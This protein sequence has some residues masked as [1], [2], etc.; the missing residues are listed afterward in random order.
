MD[1]KACK[2]PCRLS[3]FRDCRSHNPAKSL[4]HVRSNYPHR[5]PKHWI[6]RNA[7]FWEYHSQTFLYCTDSRNASQTKAPDYTSTTFFRCNDTWY[8]VWYS[9]QSWVAVY[10]GLG[11]IQWPE[12]RQRDNRLLPQHSQEARL[13]NSKGGI[14]IYPGVAIR[15][16]STG[17]KKEDGSRESLWNWLSAGYRIKCT[18]YNLATIRYGI[19]Y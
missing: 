17:C 4:A 12:A 9:T 15:S 16:Q 1:L 7:T 18:I 2:R 3:S 19:W 6:A 11:R 14:C 13:W 10:L 5:P 8:R